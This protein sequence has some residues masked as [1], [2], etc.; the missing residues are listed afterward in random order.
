MNRGCAVGR[1]ALPPHI[2]DRHRP[3]ERKLLEFLPER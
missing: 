2:A 1:M 3:M